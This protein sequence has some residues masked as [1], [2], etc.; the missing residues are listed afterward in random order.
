MKP[1]IYFFR[2]E[3]DKPAVVFIHGLGMDATQWLSPSETRILAGAFRFSIFTRKAPESLIFKEKIEIL[4]K[5]FTIGNPV[6]LNTSL[7][8]LRE[9]GYSVLTW[10]QTNPLGSIHYAVEELKNVVKFASSLSKKGVILIGNSRGGLIGR[11]FIENSDEKIKALITI[12]T[13]HRGSTLAKWVS[14][15]SKLT[16]II[17]PFLKFLPEGIEKISLRLID[18]LQCDGVREL[19]PESSFIK[20]L[21]KIEKTDFFSLAG[22][23]ST[24]FSIYEWK[25]REENDLFILYP[26]KVFSF[27]QSLFSFLPE[28]LIPPEWKSGDGVVSVESATDHNTGKVFALNHAEII[29]SAE[30]RNYILEIVENL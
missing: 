4:P 9:R 5:K 24:L 30:S 13:P 17:K 29:V 2:G 1:P 12:A 6:P 18:F 25:Q 22:S 23:N 15:V 16:D 14:Y 21:K 11:K 19:L 8:D 10:S 7:N 27:P 28:K 3:P 26:E 20:S